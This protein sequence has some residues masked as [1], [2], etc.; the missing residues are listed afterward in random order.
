V[1]KKRGKSSLKNIK[2]GKKRKRLG[3]GYD[4]WISRK[5]SEGRII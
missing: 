1:D 3:S 2:E 4:S 5:A